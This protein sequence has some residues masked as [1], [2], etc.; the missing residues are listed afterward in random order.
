MMGPIGVGN[1]KLYTKFEVASFSHCI[2][3]SN[4]E[5]PLANGHALF[6]VG[7]YNFWKFRWQTKLKVASFSR[8]KNI[9]GEPSNFGEPPI[10]GQRPLFLLGAIL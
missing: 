3:S 7:L 5:K 10:F 1:L 9:K 8:C 6:W 4:I 2:H